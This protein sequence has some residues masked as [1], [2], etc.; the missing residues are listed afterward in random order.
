M[1][2]RDRVPQGDPEW[3]V[4]LPRDTL[5]GML[6]RGLSEPVV[7]GIREDAL[8]WPVSCAVTTHIALDIGQKS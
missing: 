6:I 5:I 1:D 7:L 4:C 8:G 2:P 3:T